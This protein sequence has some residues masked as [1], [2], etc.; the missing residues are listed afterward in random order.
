MEHALHHIMEMV[1]ASW[2]GRET[3]SM[4]CLDISGAYDSCETTAQPQKEAVT[5]PAGTLDQ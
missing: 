4:L 3:A 5:S 2:N 1:M